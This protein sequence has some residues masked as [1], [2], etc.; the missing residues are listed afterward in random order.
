MLNLFEF[1][2]CTT[3]K[4]R[5]NTNFEVVYLAHKDAK[6]FLVSLY[7]WFVIFLFNLSYLVVVLF[8]HVYSCNLTMY[9]PILKKFPTLTWKNSQNNNAGSWHFKA[10]SVSIMCH[11]RQN[12]FHRGK[13]RC[14]AL[15][16]VLNIYEFGIFKNPFT[17]KHI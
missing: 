14:E 17:N 10:S 12:R 13:N 11:K 2:N 3:Y 1:Q 15:S 16:S 9:I 6:E 5:C 4:S 8:V 7:L